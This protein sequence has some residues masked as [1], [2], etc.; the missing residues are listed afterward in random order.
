MGSKP[1]T[2][3]KRRV[4]ETKAPE[5]RPQE[6][7]PTRKT[8]LKSDGPGAVVRR[9]GKGERKRS[10]RE[11]ERKRGRE[12]K[13]NKREGRWQRTTKEKATDE[14]TQMTAGEKK[15]DG[16]EVK[17]SGLQTLIIAVCQSDTR[18][19]RKSSRQ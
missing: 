12:L 16:N 6:F 17:R 9:G 18:W 14:L 4:R 13:N 5:E 1:R 3:R 15:E 2:V 7:R 11:R 8:G 10:G 19:L